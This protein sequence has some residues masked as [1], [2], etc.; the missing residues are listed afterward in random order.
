MT[1]RPLAAEIAKAPDPRRSEIKRRVVRQGQGAPSG[2]SLH[3]T[4]PK[5]PQP[6][7]GRQ[8]A[9]KRL[10]ERSWCLGAAD[11]DCPAQVLTFEFQII[12]PAMLAPFDER[13]AIRMGGIGLHPRVG[14]T[15]V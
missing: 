11:K 1:K 4:V 3:P 6:A 2:S 7:A 9:R 13:V 5:T 12:L 10:L 14:G 8:T 15:P